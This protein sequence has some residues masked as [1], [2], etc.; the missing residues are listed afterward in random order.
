MAVV[1]TA[2]RVMEIATP[3]G[4]DVLLFH[5]MNIREELGRI[6][7]FEIDLL[8]TRSDI[9]YSDI[10]SKNVTVRIE[11]SDGDRFFNG[12]VTR[13]AHTGTRGRYQ[14]YHASVRPWLWF[15][16]RKANCRIFQ[17]M[18]A[19]EIIQKIFQD[20][21][22]A[23]FKLEL[24]GAYRVRE[25]CVQYRET[26][27]NF[28]SRLMEQEGIYYYFKHVSGRHTMVVTDSYS[29]HG[30]F[31]GYEQIPFI[32]VD[33][34]RPEQEAITHWSVGYEVQSGKYT[35][36]D[37]H[38]EGPYL[39]R[40]TGYGNARK[41]ELSE[42]EIYD[43]PGEYITTGEG[44]HYVRTRLEELH[45]Q[46]EVIDAETSC[47]GLCTGNL[48]KL[49]GHPREDA[50]REF[51]IIGSTHEL[52]Y[53]EYESMQGVGSS[54]NCAFKAISS[55]Q[56]FRAQRMAPKPVVQGP[57]TALVTGP[58]GDEIYTDKFGRVK[59]QFH[60]DRE[61][62][63]DENA[64]CWIRVSQNWAGKR[65]GA[66]FLPRIGQEVIVDFLEGDPDRPIITG[67]VYNSD[68]MPPYTLPDEMTKSTIKT[69]SSK[70][71]DGFNELRFEDK[72]DSEQ[73]FIHA[74]RNQDNR[75]KKDSLEWIG[76]DRH[77]IVTRDQMEKVDGDKHLTV[78]GDQNEKVAGTVS[79]KVAADLQQKVGAKHAVD[80]GQEI[81]LK[82]GTNLV[83]ECG[84]SLTLKV[85]GNFVNLNAGGVYIQGTMVYINSGG[86]AGTGSGC[87]PAA[88]T[89]PQEADKAEPGA[90]LDAPKAP[91]PPGPAAPAV[92]MQP[93]SSS[94]QTT[95][96]KEAAKSGVPFCE[97][98]E[99]AR[100]AQQQAA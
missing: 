57:Q 28:I 29:G 62:K 72:K 12:F 77:L 11:T 10:L 18:K 84:T 100:R 50:G 54:Y 68:A 65:W 74:Q 5:R 15:L 13:F 26:D 61:G 79:L 48:F 47:R 67:R 86:A 42:Y 75:V 99:E 82:A 45:A 41:H 49:N 35:L 90:K 1:H 52:Q 98:C 87:S 36:N 59:V 37:F 8:S 4:P 55:R 23:D 80:A 25:Y 19:P 7:E 93:A 46:F 43:Y 27:F 81:H 60:W 16:T 78:K 32:P 96:L 83:I 40:W 85:G 44:D 76:Q 51:L 9:K 91:A 89:A 30:S 63:R 70:G 17:K 92:A 88:P 20:H 33:R 34:V 31:A 97:K 64:S 3:L 24:H 21:G 6:S 95:A 2:K 53:G 71:G 38:F 39:D 14:Q 58:A 73:I 66:M 69:Y 22:I 94:S 56:P